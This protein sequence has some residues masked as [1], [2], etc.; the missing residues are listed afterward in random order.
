MTCYNFI[1]FLHIIDL[2]LLNF[3]D[4]CQVI[5]G[6][7]QMIDDKFYINLNAKTKKLL[8]AIIL[9]NINDAIQYGKTNV[10]VNTCKPMSNWRK[11]ER[12]NAIRCFKYVVK[13]QS[14]LID[15][16]KLNQFLENI[17][18][19]LPTYN[20]KKLKTDLSDSQNLININNLEIGG[21]VQFIQLEN[22][23]VIDGFYILKH[24]FANI[25]CLTFDSTIYTLIND[26]NCVYNHSLNNIP[27]DVKENIRLQFLQKGLI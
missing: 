22:V 3:I 13:D 11:T 9:N 2:S 16:I 21:K 19:K 27:D 4:Y 1:N 14:I 12:N 8:V 23:D 26:G 20:I 18:E 24:I 10:I 17:F 25:G 15:K 6:S 7:Y 5:Q